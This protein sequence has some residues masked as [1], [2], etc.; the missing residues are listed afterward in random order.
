[1]QLRFTTT[2][3]ALA[4]ALLAPVGLQAQFTTFVPKPSK[5]AVDSSKPATIIAA[6]ARADSIT[7]MSITSMKDWVDSAAGVAP[8]DTLAA[9]NTMTATTTTTTEV[10]SAP[11]TVNGR[12]TTTTF[13]N[14]AIAPNT[15]S[16]LPAYLAAGFASLAAGL[17]LLYRLRR[18]PL[19][20]SAK[21]RR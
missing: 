4:V 5:A 9:A 8:N 16:P 7:R 20:I 18:R 21:A 15:A 17:L 3:L 6:R 13:S 11:S 12:A 2:A 1:V 19:E 10:P 14:G